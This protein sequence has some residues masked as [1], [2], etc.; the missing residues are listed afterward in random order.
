MMVMLQFCKTTGVKGVK[1]W[2]LK[3]EGSNRRKMALYWA[4]G[5][6]D[7]KMRA[8]LFFVETI[9]YKGTLY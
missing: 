1:L 6:R 9:K 5:K 3:I 2:V 7:E 4:K 8:I